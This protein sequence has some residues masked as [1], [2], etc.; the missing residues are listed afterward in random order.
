MVFTSFFILSQPLLVLSPKVNLMR[1][2][3][4]FV[5]LLSLLVLIGGAGSQDSPPAV[6]PKVLQHAAPAYPPLARQT[7]V[8]GDVRLRIATD[9]E[10]VRD[11]RVESGHPL[12]Q[13][14]AINN[15]RTWKFER[16]QP[17]TFEVTFRFKLLLEPQTEFLE[18]PGIVTLE[19]VPPEVTVD[20]GSVS[21]GTWHAEFTSPEKKFTRTLT[22]DNCGNVVYGEASEK[23]GAKEQLESGYRQGD[24]LMF[25]IKLQQTDRKRVKTFFVGK[26]MKDNI[27]GTW[28]DDAGVAG[29]WTATQIRH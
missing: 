20:C 24:F 17:G 12:L 14:A 23:K 5:L 4:V 25:M 6:L 26:M 1:I 19:A 10:A 18:S 22:L 2:A 21:L 11:V 27:V 13:Q 29:S 7:R 3:V 28:V 9:G 15:V 16:H 8:S